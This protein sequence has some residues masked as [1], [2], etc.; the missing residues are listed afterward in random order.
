MG[1]QRTAPD[2][3][4]CRGLPAPQAAKRTHCGSRGH[5]T[6]RWS[7]KRRLIASRARGTMYPS[8]PGLKTNLWR[9]KLTQQPGHSSPDSAQ[10]RAAPFTSS[11]KHFV[12][13]ESVSCETHQGRGSACQQVHTSEVGARKPQRRKSYQ[14][15]HSKARCTE[16]SKSGGHSACLDGHCQ[17]TRAIS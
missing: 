6:R 1:P 5:S 10:Y 8:Q 4:Q 15:M 14:E 9:T 17:Q 16:P 11:D 7:G 12:C 2:V 13:G 3:P